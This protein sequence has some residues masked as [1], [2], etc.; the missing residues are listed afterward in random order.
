MRFSSSTN[1]AVV[2]RLKIASRAIEEIDVIG[3]GAIARHIEEQSPARC[4]DLAKF[5]KGFS[6]RFKVFQN[7]TQHYVLER[8]C[9]PPSSEIDRSDVEL[10]SAQYSFFT[11]CDG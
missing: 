8:Q 1:P 7:F 6:W 9:L 10:R 2:A 5:Q 3:C 11:R 4:H